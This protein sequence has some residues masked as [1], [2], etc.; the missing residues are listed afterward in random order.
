[1]SRTLLIA[2]WGS[3][4]RW[5][6]AD[7][8][9]GSVSVRTCTSLPALQQ[10]LRG[11]VTTYVIAL[12]SLVDKD[13]RVTG[14][15]TCSSCY[16][17]CWSKVG[18]V[19]QDGYEAV[20]SF[21]RRLVKCIINCVY[22]VDGLE[23]RGNVDVIVA[24]AV[25]SPG[26]SWFFEG[27]VRD[28]ASKVLLE[29]GARVLKEPY[30]RIVLD[31]S[32]G[33]NFM[34][35][36]TLYVVRLLAS[37][38]LIAHGLNSVEVEVYNS[39]PYPPTTK[40]SSN[41]RCKELDELPKLNL[42]LVYEE[43]LT[44]AYVP[45]KIVGK[46]L[47][48]SAKPPK[49]LEDLLN[50]LNKLASS[51]KYVL[52]SLYYPLP[53]ALIISCNELAK[54]DVEIILNSLAKALEYWRKYVTVDH[55]K[56][57]VRRTVELVP[58]A[59]Y[60]LLLSAAT[61][62]RLKNLG[63]LGEP[64]VGKLKRMSKDVYKNVSEIDEALITQEVSHLELACKKLTREVGKC[65]SYSELRGEAKRECKPDRRTMI[66]HA[67][68]QKD[69]VEVCVSKDGEYVVRYV[70]DLEEMLNEDLLLKEVS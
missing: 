18:Q 13:E 10:V 34:P 42:N 66:A 20:E 3:P 57:L 43:D 54:E 44:S 32:H 48:L 23:L 35:A 47:K 15:S 25:G 14:A 52:S 22:E 39:D 51:S 31:L 70:K 67:G 69:C 12:D 61:C 40:R 2:T 4:S 11:D 29:L 56:R 50:A 60:S 6:C 33:I 1:L 30:D 53:L 38:S 21:V 49:D 16:S 26:G 63:I 17:S 64:T 46:V 9:C 68:L 24:P 19:S 5:G 58:E 55:D 27:G 41:L 36:E 62:G 37:L 65:V 7:Y 59:I 8:V 45:S 28:F